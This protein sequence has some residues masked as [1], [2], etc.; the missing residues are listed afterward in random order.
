[1]PEL[2]EV[3][4]IR[5][6][7]NRVLV[8]QRIKKIE[9]LHQ[10]SLQGSS[11]KVISK[12]IVA[13]KRKAKTIWIDLEGDANLLIHL[14]MTGQ[15]I[16]GGQAGKHTRVIFELSRGRLIFND[17]RLF[18]WIKVVD[19]KTLEKHFAGLPPD[20]VDKEFTP[21]Y[22]RKI[23]TSSGRAVK[24]VLT[25][26]QKLGGVGNIYANDALYCA[27]VNPALAAKKV[28]RT[29]E[30]YRCVKQV[31]SRGIKYGGSTARDENYVNA[32][33][34]K[35]KYQTKFLVYEQQGKKC[36]RCSGI[37]KKIKLGGRGTYFCPSC[38]K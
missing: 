7:L 21:N 10:K 17:L 27:R 20:V 3:E 37:I 23:L 14:K 38:Q 5:R 15:L 28:T 22:L 24:L 4:T 16:Y 19:N 13:V 11:L 32:L 2:P 8:G 34:Q 25:D 18:G 30:L 9:K 12:K 1:M 29:K 26:Q 6:Q 33:G 35:G 36:P 31:I